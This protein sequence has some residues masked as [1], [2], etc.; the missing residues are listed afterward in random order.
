MVIETP[1]EV[2][3]FYIVPGYPSYVE[4]KCRSKYS[5]KTDKRNTIGQYYERV[6]NGIEANRTRIIE[7]FQDETFI[8]NSI[9][10]QRQFGPF[11]EM[12][13]IYNL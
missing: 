3:D 13:K 8:E 11:K 5:K 4:I 12:F 6:R 7:Q 10:K 1:R 2:E 9:R